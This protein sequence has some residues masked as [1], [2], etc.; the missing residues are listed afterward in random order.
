MFNSVAKLPCDKVSM[1]N[2]PVPCGK[3]SG[4][5]N[6]ISHTGHWHACI[7]IANKYW[8]QKD[9]GPGPSLLCSST[10]THCLHFIHQLYIRAHHKLFRLNNDAINLGLQQPNR[11]IV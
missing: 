10:S 6:V 2:L 11:L 5:R 3:V 1:A 4:K 9:T 7:T 8:S